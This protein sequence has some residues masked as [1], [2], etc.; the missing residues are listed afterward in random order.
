MVEQGGIHAYDVFE[1][2]LCTMQAA[3]DKGYSTSMRIAALLH[4][5]G[6]PA[7]R[8]TGGKN[9]MYTFFGH[10]VVGAR[11][12]KKTLIALNIHVKKLKL[13]KK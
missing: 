3:A 1:H 11:M 9:K 8:R 2:L 4:D 7:T 12:I 10:E 13:S 6:K 5:V